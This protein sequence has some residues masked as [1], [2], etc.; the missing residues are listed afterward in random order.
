MLWTGRILSALA[1]LFL[2]FDATIKLF[3]IQPVV[4]ASRLLGLPVDLAPALGVILLACL[5][6][7]LLPRTAALGAVLLTGY[8]GGA[9]AIQARVGAEPF[10]LVFPVILGALLWGGLYL[11]D[12]RVRALV[13]SRR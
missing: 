5:A 8:L 1:V 2:T 12:K 7:Y 10:S 9:I 13:A 3:N 6:I 4:D 11:R